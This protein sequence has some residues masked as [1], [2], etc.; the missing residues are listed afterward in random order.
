MFPGQAMEKAHSRQGIAHSVQLQ[1]TLHRNLRK[2]RDFFE[3]Y[4]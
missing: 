1:V 2:S 4:L 3:Y